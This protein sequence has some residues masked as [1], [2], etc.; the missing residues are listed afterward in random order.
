MEKET[1]NLIKNMVGRNLKLNFKTVEFGGIGDSFGGQTDSRVWIPCDPDFEPIK[2]Q[3][4]VELHNRKTWESHDEHELYLVQLNN[5][6][7]VVKD[8]RYVTQN[9]T[10]FFVDI[11]KCPQ[12]KNS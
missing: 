3:E 4:H 11:Y 8:S 2:V 10:D 5:E 1:E 12:I 7:F 9:G 6:L